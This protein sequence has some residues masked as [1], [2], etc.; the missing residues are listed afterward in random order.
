LIASAREKIARAKKFRAYSRV[1]RKL[2]MRKKSLFHRNILNFANVRA[3]LRDASKQK[4]FCARRA[5][6]S[7]IDARHMRAAYTFH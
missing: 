2:S 4:Q 3:L 5:L 1:T 6:A 7:H